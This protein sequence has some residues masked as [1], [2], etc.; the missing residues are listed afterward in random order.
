MPAKL[1]FSTLVAMALSFASAR[2]E[3]ADALPFRIGVLTDMGGFSAS[4]SG[5]GSLAAAQMAVEDFGK[6]ILD[7]P[8]EIVSADHQN[9]PDVGSGIARQW[10]QNE[11]VSAIFDVPNSSVAFAVQQLAKDND[12]LVFFSTSGSSDLSGKACNTNSVVWSYNTYAVAKTAVAA[13]MKRGG[14]S[15]FFLSGDY[16][17]AK[18]M[19]GDAARLFTAAGGTVAGSVHVPIGTSDFS[20]FLLAA[21]ASKAKVMMITVSGDDQANALKQAHEF[22]LPQRGI[23]LASTFT[24]PL[25][26]K[27]LGAEAAEGFVFSSSWYYDINPE[28]RAFAERFVK[29]T[30]SMPSMFQAGVYS[31]VS[32][33]L[34]AVQATGRDDAGSVMTKLRATP[35]KDLF[36]QD[37]RVRIDGQMIHSMYLLEG[38]GAGAMKDGWDVAKILASVSPDDAFVPLSESACPLARQ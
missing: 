1:R 6:T 28:A 4:V 15:W 35:I 18:A 3:A 2:A 32:S 20:S 26:L 21:Q 9:K 10:Y 38:K 24:E 31:A 25:V 37:G 22:G 12:K 14:N 19:E 33:Y 36:T 23:Q 7:R 17:G 5:R 16:A 11:G 30:G 13:L 8:I 27:S 34:R 29:A